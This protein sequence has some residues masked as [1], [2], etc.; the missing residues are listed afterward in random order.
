MMPVST[1]A[2]FRQHLDDLRRQGKQYV[3]LFLREHDGYRSVALPLGS[4]EAAHPRG[5]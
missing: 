5:G 1:P 4:P 3:L 2:E